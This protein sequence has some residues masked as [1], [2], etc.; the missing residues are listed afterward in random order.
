MRN[1][2]NKKQLTKP[3]TQKAFNER[4]IPF[5][6]LPPGITVSNG[7]IFPDILL[8]SGVG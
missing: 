1:K 3:G 2:A 7:H 4:Q 6:L 5:M 8:H